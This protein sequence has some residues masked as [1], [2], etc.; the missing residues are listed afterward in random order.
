M[1]FKCFDP[2]L[3]LLIIFM[4]RANLTDIPTTTHKKISFPLHW[5]VKRPSTF[6]FLQP[7]ITVI[8]PIFYVEVTPFK[9]FVPIL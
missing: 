7:H 4:C 2:L 3:L 9:H 1:L 6:S 5:E 8:H